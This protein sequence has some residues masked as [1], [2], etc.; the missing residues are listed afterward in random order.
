MRP[1]IRYSLMYVSRGPE[2]W[3]PVLKMTLVWGGEIV[4]HQKPQVH[5]KSLDLTHSTQSS[6]FH[7]SK[8]TICCCRTNLR[9]PSFLLKGFCDATAGTTTRSLPST[10]TCATWKG[11]ME[12]SLPCLLF[13][14][15]DVSMAS[16]TVVFRR[17]CWISCQ[18]PIAMASLETDFYLGLLS[19][20]I[21]LLWQTELLAS[22][23]H[24]SLVVFYIHIHAG[25]P[26]GQ[27]IPFHT[28]IFQLGYLTWFGQG[29]LWAGHTQKLEIFPLELQ[30]F[31]CGEAFTHFPF[32]SGP[33]M[34]HSE[35]YP[36]WPQMIQWYMSNK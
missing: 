31:P 2:R 11:T 32:N 13:V 1:R 28:M 35:N 14:W 8:L 27:I 34:S 17:S 26:G 5:L 3:T 22:I 36:N 6:P 29:I 33:R 25:T 4:L 9:A 7:S 15:A 10:H 16:P 24:L 19:L 30:P 18:L 12:K 23:L 21:L 20:P